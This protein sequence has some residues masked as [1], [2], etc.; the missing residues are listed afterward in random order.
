MPKYKFKI[1]GFIKNDEA[2]LVEVF[3]GTALLFT[4]ELKVSLDLDM[5]RIK[6]TVRDEIEKLEKEN[7]LKNKFKTH[8]DIL[9]KEIDKKIDI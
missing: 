1:N 7:E 4:K 6:R 3:D 9:K 5:D 8:I 2:V